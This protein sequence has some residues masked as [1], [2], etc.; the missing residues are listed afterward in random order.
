MKKQETD[1]NQDV[2][3]PKGAHNE[4]IKI[5]DNSFWFNHRNKII[6]TIIKKYPIDGDFADIG[7]GNG[8]QLLKVAKLNKSNKNILIEPSKQGCA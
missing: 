7:G 3:F 4:L 1:K 8:Y 6:E 5:E 2:S